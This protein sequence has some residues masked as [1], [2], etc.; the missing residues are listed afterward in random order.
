[1]SQGPSKFNFGHW[2]LVLGHLLATTVLF[3]VQQ[4][5]AAT[6]REFDFGPIVSR[7]PDVYGDMRLKAAGPIFDRARS[8]DEVRTFKAVR[9]FYSR[10]ADSNALKASSHY[11]WPVATRTQ[12]KSEEQWRVILAF[13]F[14]HNYTNPTPRYRFWLIPFYF[15]G[16]DKK[17]ETYRAV[18]PLGGSIHEFLGRDEINFILFPIRSTSKLNDL[19]TS[20]WLWPFIA[21]TRGD[22]T[23]RFRVFPFYGISTRE[24]E[25]RKRFVLWPF[26]NS[27][28]YAYPGSSGSGYILFPLWGRME[29]ENQ[30]TTWVLPPFFRFTKGVKA[31][32]VHCPWPFFTYQRGDINK[33]YVWPLYGRKKSLVI[34]R[35]YYAW[36]FIWN[37]YLNQS[38]VYR[39][40]FSVVPFF[41][42][43][44]TWDR[45]AE[46]N[47]TTNIVGRYSKL[48]PLYSYRRIDDEY[49]FRM[50]ELW[51]LAE[52][53]GIERN[54]APFWSLYTRSG[55][56]GNRE[57]EVL[58]GMYR[59]Q[60]REDGSRYWSLFPLYERKKQADP[61]L[62]RWSVLKG[63]MGRETAGDEARW[64][65]LYFIRF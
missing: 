44:T 17:G 19:E 32:L 7:H 59:S 10:A 36:P 1:M 11:L 61:P 35:T 30:R 62:R 5:H 57:T 8:V 24:N 12:F 34:D 55:K 14:N 63:L 45:D 6:P 39:H 51:P 3:P 40:R 22:D 43:E 2:L 47:V 16:R 52:A 28:Q 21:T 60:A 20:N 31:D 56:G 58:W 25:Y 41:H 54:W 29:L 18:F 27:A 46:H 38:T 53:P 50:L 4:A 26:W 9:P 64:R 65:L 13:G 48:W 23:Y 49:R 42:W 15:Q 37:T 33:L